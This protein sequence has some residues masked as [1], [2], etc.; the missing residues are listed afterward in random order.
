MNV[1]YDRKKAKA[2]QERDAPKIKSKKE[3]TTAP[4]QSKGCGTQLQRPTK[5]MA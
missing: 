5:N 1:K 3:P 2:K 4:L